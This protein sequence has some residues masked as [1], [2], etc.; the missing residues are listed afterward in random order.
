[1]S[2]SVRFVV[3]D[4][5]TLCYEGITYNESNALEQAKL[6]VKEELEPGVIVTIYKLVPFKYIKKV[7]SIVEVLAKEPK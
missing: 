2:R 5:D 6:L 3:G 4:C 1:M 7:E